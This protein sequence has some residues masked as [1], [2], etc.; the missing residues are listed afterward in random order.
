[1][2]NYSI[3]YSTRKTI[4]IEDQRTNAKIEL[5]PVS[6]ESSIVLESLP[7]AIVAMEPVEQ[8]NT[9]LKKISGKPWEHAFVIFFFLWISEYHQ[10]V[11]DNQETIEDWEQRLKYLRK[12]LAQIFG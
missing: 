9:L 1:M 7:L 8:I 6:R 3:K 2:S 10:E 4:I 12:V 5:S 11:L